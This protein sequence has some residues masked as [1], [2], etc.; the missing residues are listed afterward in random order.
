MR[1]SLGLRLFLAAIISTAVA[2]AATAVVLN[3]LFRVYFEDRVQDELETYLLMLTGN[4][5]VNAAGEIEISPLS[6]PRF[7]Q[8]LSG[9]YWQISI[10]TDAPILSPSFWAAP[11]VLP[12]PEQSG[13]VMFQDVTT[14][15]G[16][17]FTTASWIVTLGE[18]DSTQQVFLTV[19]FDRAG[20]DVSISGFTTNSAVW[21]AILGLFLL[22]ASWLT[23]RVGLRPLEKVRAEVNRVT[24]VQDTRLSDDYPTEVRP[25]VSAVNE[26]LDQNAQSL[27]RVRTSAG[28]LAHGLKTPLTIMRGISR[29][30]DKVGQKA[31]AI[32][33]NAEIDNMQHIVERELA[34]SRDSQQSRTYVAV[35]PIVARLGKALERLPGAEHVRWVIDVQESLTAPFDAFDLTELLGNLLDNALKWTTDVVVVRGGVINDRAFLSVADDGPGI[36]EGQH[37]TAMGRGKMLDPDRSGSGLGLAIVQDMA[38][39]HG[40]EIVLE[41]AQSGGLDVKLS[42]IVPSAH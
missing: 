34:R 26:L 41:T 36:P 12:R 24:Y 17:A 27:A 1:S 29:D 7:A 10:D 40:C 8:A 22:A 6:D 37:E 42:W 3:V 20:L 15:T 35:A 25:L 11:L 38:Q 2:L 39:S 33:L 18:G 4:I 30:M 9:Y 13:I 32:D 14:G 31:L 16:D 28:N 5:A 23:A 21:L 19:A